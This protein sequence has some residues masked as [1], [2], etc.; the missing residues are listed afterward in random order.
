MYALSNVDDDFCENVAVEAR[1][2]DWNP[3]KTWAAVQ[4]FFDKYD[5]EPSHRGVESLD[6]YANADEWLDDLIESC[7]DDLSAA[8]HHE[9]ARE[10]VEWY[11]VKKQAG[12]LLREANAV[13][14]ENDY[15]VFWG[16]TEGGKSV[17]HDAAILRKIV[18]ELTPQDAW[19]WTERTRDGSL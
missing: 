6:E 19:F 12:V 2:E 4:K 3:A 9:Q 11:M 10:V 1:V 18:T 5:L 17:V 15:G 14:L 13:V 8:K 16:R 7:M